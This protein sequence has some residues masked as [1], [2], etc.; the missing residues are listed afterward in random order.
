MLE[1]EKVNLRLVRER[2]LDELYTQITNLG[3][4]GDYFPLTLRGEPQFKQDFQS[5]GFWSDS[6]GR[7]IIENKNNEMLGSIYYF[8][9]VV[10][11]DALE[12]GYILFNEAHYN[13]GYTQE[14]LKLMT[15][16][17]FAVKKI[18]RLQLG[19]MPNHSASIAVAKKCGFEY[20]ATL[21]QF[22][23]LH[24]EYHDMELFVLLRS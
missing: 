18:N 7:F 21:K 8:N 2:D 19:I 12:L 6:F 20:E 5:T 24:G 15:D 22:T 4:R 23:Y 14:A 16:Y 11:S 10:Y 9:T 13:Q 1:G 3:N 17:L